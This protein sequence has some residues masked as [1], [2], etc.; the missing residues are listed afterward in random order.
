MLKAGFGVSIWEESGDG[1]FEELRRLLERSRCAFEWQ[2][3]S[4]DEQRRSSGEQRFFF[5]GQR[6]SDKVESDSV[7]AETKRR[8]QPPLAFFALLS[9]RKPWA[10]A[11]YWIWKAKVAHVYRVPKMIMKNSLYMYIHSKVY[12]VIWQTEWEF[13]HQKEESCIITKKY[14]DTQIQ[15]LYA[16]ILL[17][18]TAEVE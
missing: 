5:E 3:R 1:S 11:L 10:Y 2:W 6:S 12:V 15:T 9:L 17:F 7:E 13:V 8:L 16:I 14:C 4:S 18:Y